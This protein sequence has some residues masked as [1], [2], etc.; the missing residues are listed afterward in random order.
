MEYGLAGQPKPEIEIIE[1]IGYN[2]TFAE[3]GETYTFMHRWD[4]LHYFS[5]L[6][7]YCLKIFDNDDG[8]V[9][10]WV[11]EEAAQGVVEFTGT[12]VNERDTITREEYEAF[13][14]SQ[15]GTE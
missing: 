9:E 14:K 12:K 2:I 1:D 7:A 15:G 4:S 3:T 10:A 11:N 5:A 13:R 8:L 6:G